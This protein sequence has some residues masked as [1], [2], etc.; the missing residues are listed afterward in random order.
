[1]HHAFLQPCTKGLGTQKNMELAWTESV[2]DKI[3]GVCK[4]ARGHFGMKLYNN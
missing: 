4:Q 1:M 3:C 2:S